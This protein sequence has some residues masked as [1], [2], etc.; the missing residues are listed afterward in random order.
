MPGGCS[1]FGVYASALFMSPSCVLRST[2]VSSIILRFCLAGREEPEARPGVWCGC[3]AP[4]GGICRLHKRCADR[5]QNYQPG[6]PE[7]CLDKCPACVHSCPGCEHTS[8]AVVAQ[9]LLSSWQCKSSL[10]PSPRC[11]IDHCAACR[12]MAP[13]VFTCL[14]ECCLTQ[15]AP[16]QHHKLSSHLALLQP[17]VLSFCSLATRILNIL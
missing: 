5:R 6:T 3:I 15:V 4:L 8:S 2:S 13:A 14:L 16:R 1:I 7:C 10:S 9:L 11:G 17:T 12:S